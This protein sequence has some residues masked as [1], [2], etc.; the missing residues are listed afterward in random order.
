MPPAGD[1]VCVCEGGKVPD[2]GEI[3]VLLLRQ[4][5]RDTPHLPA[6]T[7][8]EKVKASIDISSPPLLHSQHTGLKSQPTHSGFAG[9]ADRVG[10]CGVGS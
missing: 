4:V 6:S 9:T 10:W 1:R 7:E 2:L 8:A 3:S 5:P